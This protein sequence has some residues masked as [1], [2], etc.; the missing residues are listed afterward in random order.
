MIE[1]RNTHDSD[2]KI[3]IVAVIG[4]ILMMIETVTMMLE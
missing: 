2:D 3:M 4:I 1:M